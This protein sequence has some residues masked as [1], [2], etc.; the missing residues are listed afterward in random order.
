[1]AEAENRAS[2]LCGATR[3]EIRGPIHHAR[4]CHCGNCRKF[5]GASHAAWGLV[6]TDHL[7][8]LTPDAPI[9]RYNAGK[10][11]RAFCRS[12][13]SPLWFEPEALPRYR[14]IP[15]GVIDSGA[16]PSPDMHVWTGSKVAWAEIADG[17]PQHVTHP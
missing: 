12:C 3:Y 14:G 13:G 15:L 5:S 17:L 1:M 4:F 16:V 11:E 9:T 2:C 6:A 7:V 8:L 10:G